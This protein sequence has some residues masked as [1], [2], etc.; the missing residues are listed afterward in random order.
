MDFLIHGSGKW[1]DMASYEVYA[2]GF[3]SNRHH[4]TSPIDLECFDLGGK[5]SYFPTLVEYFP[6]RPVRP[7]PTAPPAAHAGRGRGGGGAP[8]AEA[9]GPK[10]S[11]LTDVAPR[12]FLTC[13]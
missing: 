6:R 12:C 11:P 9:K 5:S 10:N 1:H 2:A 8:P 13:G 4:K 3:W 7:H